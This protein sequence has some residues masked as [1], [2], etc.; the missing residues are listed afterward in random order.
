MN[1]SEGKRAQIQ[2]TTQARNQHRSSDHMSR[3]SHR[4][5]FQKFPA[6]PRHPK[7]EANLVE[8]LDAGPLANGEGSIPAIQPRTCSRPLLQH[9]RAVVEHPPYGATWCPMTDKNTLW[10]KMTGLSA[11]TTSKVPAESDPGHQ[12]PWY[13]VLHHVQFQVRYF[14]RVFPPVACVPVYEL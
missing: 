7:A 10:L 9:G 3:T 4:P 12:E 6:S 11:E 1:G 8:A 13:L 2:Q 14:H 5:R